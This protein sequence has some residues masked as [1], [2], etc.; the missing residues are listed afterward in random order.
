MS[1]P[2]ATSASA[3][4]GARRR[5]ARL[6]IRFAKLGKVRWTSHRDVAR[7]WER[8][9]RRARLPL[10]YSQGFSP[11]PRVSFGLALP[12]GHESLAEYLDVELDGRCTEDLPG[13]A[14]RL[15][16]A[17]PGGVD[18]LVA[19]L[20]DPETPSLQEEVT[21]CSWEWTAV[22]RDGAALDPG[23]MGE[24]CSELLAGAS[25]V[26]ARWRKGRE[27]TDDVREV[28]VDLQVVG[29]AAGAPGEP[30]G[31]RL[32]AELS[33]HPRSLRPSE[34]LSGLARGERLEERD[35]RRLDQWISRG[36]AR[37]EP[38]ALPATATP[39]PHAMER[40]S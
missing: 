25:L 1:A 37:R 10:A 2:P 36:G 3:A 5:A 14:G 28:V 21:S 11:R 27:V 17:L 4:G 9:F 7:M 20:V 39:A 29:P 24:R 31:V 19:A 12:T 26:L 13:L 23:E 34:L 22:D 32:R 40:A 16:A 15:S 30:P 38:L 18:V 33:C 8:A 35:A 6:R